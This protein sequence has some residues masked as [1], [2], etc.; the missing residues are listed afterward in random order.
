MYHGDKP[1]KNVPA[2]VKENGIKL[3][4]WSQKTITAAIEKASKNRE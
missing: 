1:P 4:P 3:I 2:A